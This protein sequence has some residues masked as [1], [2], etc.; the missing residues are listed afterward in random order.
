[1]TNEPNLNII[2]VDT[3]VDVPNSNIALI[4]NNIIEKNSVDVGNW[5]WK[6]IIVTYGMGIL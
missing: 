4:C 5:A 6:Y 2:V 1:M 3:E